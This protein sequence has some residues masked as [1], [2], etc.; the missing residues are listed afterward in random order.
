MGAIH[1]VVAKSRRQL[2]GKSE[3]FDSVAAGC[4][5]AC[6]EPRLPE[7]IREDFGVAGLKHDL[8]E[9]DDFAGPRGPLSVVI[10]AHWERLTL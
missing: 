2:V 10:G 9:V 5:N 3:Q 6:D 1:L 8:V 4:E 7:E